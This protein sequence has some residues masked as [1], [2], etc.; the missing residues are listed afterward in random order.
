MRTPKIS[1]VW[2]HLRHACVHYIRLQL[3]VHQ[4][5]VIIPALHY[6]SL[7]IYAFI[8]STA[9]KDGR[10]PGEVFAFAKVECTSVYAA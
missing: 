9:D 7:G 1:V 2:E 6:L 10:H 5:A 8:T 4:E 3:G